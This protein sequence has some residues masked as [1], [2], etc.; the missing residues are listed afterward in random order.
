MPS[1]LE[2]SIQS[3]PEESFS[4]MYPT[5]Q[6]LD[7]GGVQSFVLHTVDD[8]EEPANRDTLFGRTSNRPQIRRTQGTRRRHSNDEDPIAEKK[9]SS[10][11]IRLA[12]TS[13]QGRKSQRIRR[14]SPPMRILTD[15]V[16]IANEFSSP[17]L[18]FKPIQKKKTLLTEQYKSDIPTHYVPI[19]EEE[20][21]PIKESEAL[22]RDQ[23]KFRIITA[24][25]HKHLVQ[26]SHILFQIVDVFGKYLAQ[27]Y[28]DDVAKI[29]KGE[30]L[31]MNTLLEFKNALKDVET[32][33]DFF[34]GS[35]CSFYKLDKIRKKE[36]S[37]GLYMTQENL[38]SFLL[39]RVFNKD[40]YSIVFQIIRVEYLRVERGYRKKFDPLQGNNPAFFGVPDDLALNQR[41]F[42][43]L[44]GSGMITTNMHSPVLKE[45]II[46]SEG[47]IQEDEE[48]K[49]PVDVEYIS[50]DFSIKDEANR[51]STNSIAVGI[52]QPMQNPRTQSRFI[53]YEKTISE[54]KKLSAKRSPVDKLKIITKS[55]ENI[56]NSIREFYREYGLAFDI[57]LECE[58]ISSI[59]TYSIAQ[60]SIPDILVHNKF[61]KRFAPKNMLLDP[62]CTRIMKIFDNS[63]NCI[64][65][66]SSPVDFKD[67]VE[68][69]PLKEFVERAKKL[70]ITF[71]EVN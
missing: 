23:K 16:S 2:Q 21:I 3:V 37:L 46:L 48:E 63:I 40:V 13:I 39:S 4:C 71:E 62:S 64:G 26:E 67:A 14:A 10:P 70:V 17:L 50:I 36:A 20:N 5:L 25:I 56:E 69:K 54:L 22:I 52:E 35:V 28:G 32:F 43:Y 57:E 42:L 11:I 1:V 53:P 15:G 6:V 24:V 31:Q 33:I 7:D 9:V 51:F 18:N 47:Q 12:P 8:N 19:F 45:T 29:T 44:I 55:I 68:S 65:A 49:H 38:G 41:T 66:I 27:K 58:K 34:V 59:L 30:K 61:I 60:C